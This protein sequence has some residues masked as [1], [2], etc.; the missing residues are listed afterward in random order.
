M[1]L[2]HLKPGQSVFVRTMTYHYIGRLLE[3]DPLTIVLDDASWVADSGRWH[4]ALAE[5]VLREVE[6]YPGKVT[7]NRGTVVDISEWLHD[8]PREAI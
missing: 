2:G 7:I 6:P 8:L 5:G 4:T 1:Q 3:S